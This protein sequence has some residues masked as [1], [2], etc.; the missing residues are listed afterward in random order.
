MPTEEKIV[1]KISIGDDSRYIAA[2]YDLDGEEITTTY[3]KADNV[4][5]KQNIIDGKIT[6]TNSEDGTETEYDIIDPDTWAGKVYV[7][8]NFI[9]T[10]EAQ[11]YIKDE[12]SNLIG[13]GEIKVEAPQ[14]KKFEYVG[15][16]DGV[17]TL[18]LAPEEGYGQILKIIIYNGGS[19]SESDTG[20]IILNGSTN[21]MKSLPASYLKKGSTFEIYNNVLLC[22]S[23]QGDREVIPASDVTQGEG[24]SNLEINSNQ[25]FWAIVYKEGW[26]MASEEGEE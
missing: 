13:K 6:I 10:S 1:K 12:I 19:S 23:H 24:W 16:D 21:S 25:P 17:T 5:T 26:K 18:Q 8:E 4:V 22:T 3:A 14:T 7:D 15:G 2:K 9:K 20:N 11:D